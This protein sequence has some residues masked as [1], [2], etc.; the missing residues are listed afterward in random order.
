LSIETTTG[1]SAPPIGTI[2]RTPSASDRPTISP[3][4]EMAFGACQH[5]DE[6]DDQQQKQAAL[7]TVAERQHDRLAGHAAVELQEG[8]DRAGK[9]D[10]ADGDAERHFDQR[11]GV[12]LADLADAEG[13]RRIERR[14]RDQT[15]ARPTSEWKPATSCG[16]EV[17]GMR[18]GDIRHRHRRRW[19][20]R[21]RSAPDR[22]GRG[23][24]QQRGDDGDTHADH[25]VG[26]CPCG[27]V[28]GCDRPR[29][30]MM[31]RTPETR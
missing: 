31:N 28:V 9:G 3:E 27:E 15:A 12:D 20:G 14:G 25:A 16:I 18:A 11:L 17:I 4:I 23:G 21:A 10:G 6:E 29:S 24:E 7:M 22:Q 5:D 8:D 13:R 2:S 19:Q 1:M 30:A 26:Y